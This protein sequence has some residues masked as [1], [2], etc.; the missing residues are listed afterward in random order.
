MRYRDFSIATGYRSLNAEGFGAFVEWLKKEKSKYTHEKYFES[1]RRGYANYILKFMEALVEIDVVSVRDVDTAR[2]RHQVAMRGSSARQV[3]RMRQTAVSPEEYARI[4]KVIRME[5]EECKA[6]LNQPAKLHDEYDNAFPLLPFTMLL[7]ASQAVRPVEFNY[8]KVRD[9]TDDRLLLN[10]PNK[11]P[12]EIQLPQSVVETFLVAQ[13]W[14]SCYRLSENPDDPLLVVP[15]K[16]G[17]RAGQVVRF[18]TI[19]L[20]HSLKKLYKKYFDLLD[21]DGMPYLFSTSSDDESELVPFSLSFSGYRSAA[22]TEAARH[23]RN[24]EVVRQFARHESFKTTL[25]FYIRET[26]QRWVENVALFLAPSAERLRISLHNKVASRGEED[27][28]KAAG[29]SVPGGHCEQAASGDKSCRRASDCRL[30]QFFRIHVSKRS[31][32]VMER[33]EAIEKANEVQSG[34]GLLRDAQNLREFAAL[35]QAIINRIDDHLAGR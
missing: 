35:N 33:D 23:E 24:P 22:I 18:D 10:A 7:G 34:Q 13:H 31:F 15:I 26:H 20:F 1:T 27:K 3:E 11:R 19:L 9:L 4:T 16:G 28:A 14:M 30:C 6:L 5:Y 12:S 29:A 21:P 2:L 17:P 32:F 8:L 25:K